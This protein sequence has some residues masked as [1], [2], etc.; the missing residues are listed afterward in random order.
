MASKSIK[1]YK[2]F[3]GF[4]LIDTIYEDLIQKVRIAF[5]KQPNQD[6]KFELIQ[7]LTEDSPVMNALRK[8]GGLNHVCYEV[9]D[10]EHTIRLFRN[11][12][13]KLISGPS[14]AVAFGNKKIAFLYTKHREVIELVEE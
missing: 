5:I 1:Y 11:N 3:F 9:S 7:P 8:G 13:S 14:S 12:G 10:I 6:L 2:K 4:E